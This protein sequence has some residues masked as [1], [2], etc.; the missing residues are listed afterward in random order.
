MERELG[1]MSLNDDDDPVIVFHV[2]NTN[3][4]QADTGLSLVGRFLTD[5][6]IRTHIMRARLSGVWR[7]GKGVTIQ[8]IEPGLFLFQ[9]YHKLDYQRI[10]NGG[11]W[12][13][14][15][16]MLVLSPLP[17]GMRPNMVQ[18]NKISI[19]VQIHG[20]PAGFMT[21]VVGETLGN[22]IGEFMEY[23]PNNNN[24]FW[25]TYMRVRVSLDVRQPL[26]RTKRTMKAGGE[27]MQVQFK[28]ERLGVFCFLCGV[29]GHVEQHCAK[30]FEIENDDGHRL[31]GA[32]LR[33]DPRRGGGTVVSKWLVEKGSGGGAV[34]G[35]TVGVPTP[36]DRVVNG[37][38]Y[39]NSN[40]A[41]TQSMINNEIRD[42]GAVMG[43]TNQEKA[44][45]IGGVNTHANTSRGFHVHPNP[46]YEPVLTYIGP[47]SPAEKKRRREVGCSNS[48]E[49]DSAMHEVSPD[50]QCEVPTSSINKHFLLA[51]PGSQACQD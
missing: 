49:Y 16:Y 21:Q 11:P 18:L 27:C 43:V 29:I 1:S 36:N 3:A 19:W 41:V 31:W 9:F 20:L 8:E 35:V 25:R 48:R 14:D 40:P 42:P 17:V 51:G 4:Q 34:T 38:N 46:T 47:P 13:F 7:P 15:N 33:A 23:D 39:G 22:F 2:D 44:V 12:S 28:Y 5:K 45:M 6:P 10:L 24:G 30:L 26:K 50:Q 32:D 37:G